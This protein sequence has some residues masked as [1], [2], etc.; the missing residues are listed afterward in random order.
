MENWLIVA[1]NKIMEEFPNKQIYS[2]S[3]ATLKHC[4]CYKENIPILVI[5]GA[6]TAS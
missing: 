5:M 6:I 4:M 2:K 3:T 1:E